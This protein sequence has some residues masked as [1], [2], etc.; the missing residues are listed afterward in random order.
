MR[1]FKVIGALLCLAFASSAHASLTAADGGL[2]VY[3]SVSNVTWTANGSLF[4]TQLASNAGLVN[5]IIA[6]WGG[7]AFPYP[8]SSQHVLSASDF[9]TVSANG[10]PPAGTMTWWGALAWVNYLND[11]AYG[12]HTNWRLPST[13]SDAAQSSSGFPDG[14]PGDPAVGSSEMAQLFYGELGMKANISLSS[15]SISSS[16][17]GALAL[18]NNLHDYSYWSG[19]Q[20][21]AG[22]SAWGFS[23]LTGHQGNNGKP[24]YSYVLAVSPNEITAVPLPASAWLLLS[25]ILAFAARSAGP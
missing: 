16:C 13:V 4:S 11:T 7:Q 12:G 17:P 6:D 20:N 1:T 21:N 19:T 8:D 24:F 5:T 18:F 14:A 9:T 23:T 15:C 2:G 25:G 10:Y 22:V 3:D